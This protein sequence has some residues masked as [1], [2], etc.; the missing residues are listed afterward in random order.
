MANRKKISELPIVAALD[1]SEVVPVVQAGLTSRTLLSAITNYISTT[2]TAFIQAGIGAFARSNQSKLR[3]KVSLLDFIPPNLHTSIKDGTNITDLA[4]YIQAALDAAVSVEAPAGIYLASTIRLNPRNSLIGTGHGGTEFK[5][6]AATAGD[7]IALKTNTA[8]R[9]VLRDFAVNGNKANQSVANKGINFSNTGSSAAHTSASTMGSNDPRHLL[10]NLLIY[11]TKGDGLFMDGRGEAMVDSIWTYRCDGHGIYNNT[12]D[13]WFSNLSSGGSGL[14]GIFND[15][16]AYDC[17]FTNI[18]AWFSGM[19]DAVNSGDG[20]NHK[21][22]YCVFSG[23]EIQDSRRHGVWFDSAGENV[24]SG[25]IQSPGFVGNAS[26][27]F[28]IRDSRNN[29]IIATIHERDA[30]PSM[31]YGMRFMSGGS[32]VAGNDVTL[33]VRNAQTANYLFETAGFSSQLL[34]RVNSEFVSDPLFSGIARIP[35]RIRIK[36]V[37]TQNFDIREPNAEEVIEGFSSV[38]RQFYSS[39]HAGLAGNIHDTFGGNTSGGQYQLN[40]FTGTVL[41]GVA[42]GF[43]NGD[44]GVA[45]GAWNT[46]CLRIGTYRLWV[47]ATGDLRIKSTAPTSD[48]D[49]TV[50]GTQS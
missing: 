41:T 1:G 46:G 16:A 14:H 42:R 19:V 10:H 6:F 30:S 20:L 45:G 43:S 50:V 31:P 32:G 39:A 35:G 25:H 21:G 36:N 38:Q 12:F 37:S 4:T 48:L 40:H 33:T 47:D 27:G 2:A 13:S 11:D 17:R 49:G 34:L 15:A 26:D 22:Y 29:L 7:F 3:D 5:Q 44:F 23:V 24:F 28:R 9:I 8:E 18:K